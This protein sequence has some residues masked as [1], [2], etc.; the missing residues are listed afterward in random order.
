MAIS[1]VTSGLKTGAI[2]GGTSTATATT[3]ADLIVIGGGW[4]QNA[5]TISDS[6]GN[7][8]TGLTARSS[9]T[10]FNR[11]WYCL[12]PTT[13]A[14]HTFTIAGTG[15]YAW[16]GFLAF[17]GVASYDAETGA[18]GTGTSLAAGSLTPAVDGSLLI[19]SATTAGTSHTVNRGYTATTQNNVGG[20]SMGGGIAYLI[21]GTAAAVNPT[22]SWTGSGVV[23]ASHA[24]FSPTA[25][26][27]VYP[28]WQFNRRRRPLF[29]G[30]R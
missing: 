7:T 27:T 24:R 15:V 23:A 5:V 11:L 13:S 29:W 21:Q 17:S 2:N 1:L 22:W 19:T 18:T 9:S 20:T 28:H 8:W 4:Y 30:V 26:S 6:A 25:G 16:V 10:A 14:S 3:G 12:N